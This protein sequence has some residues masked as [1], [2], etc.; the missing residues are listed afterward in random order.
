MSDLLDRLRGEIHGRLDVTRAAVTEYE[1]LEAALAALAAVNGATSAGPSAKPRQARA[2]AVTP[3]PR[4]RPVAARA[5]RAPR[6]ANRAAVLKAASERPGASA[7][8]LAAASGVSRPVVYQL[9]KTLT[10]RGELVRH[11]LPSAVAGYAP[12]S[13]PSAPSTFD[14]TAA[15]VSTT[16]AAT[17]AE[18]SSSAD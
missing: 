6:G 8:E 2:S 4:S 15:G 11:A 12:A 3:A 14:A 18:G 16:A 1:Q 10:E 5:S 13:A 9:L 7:G 17:R